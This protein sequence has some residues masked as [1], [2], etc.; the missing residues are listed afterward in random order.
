MRVIMPIFEFHYEG[1]EFKFSDNYSLGHFDPKKD[2][3]Q[4]V[5]NGLSVLD[6]S[7]ISQQSWA[8]VVTNPSEYFKEELNLLL[9]AFRIY[10]KSNVFI[11]W[12]FCEENPEFSTCL[13]DRFRNL[14]TE[15]FVN[16]TEED[17]SKVKDG[18]FKIIEMYS[19]SDR[20]KNALYFIWRGFCVDKH[21]DAYI[22]LVCAIESL[23]SGETAEEVTKTLIKR[24]QYFLSG[25]K[26]F[27]GNQINKIYEIR[28]DMVHGRIS[29][30][31]KANVVK[32]QKNLNNL[33]KLEELVFVCMKKMLDNKI[34]LKYRNIAEKEDFLNN[35]LNN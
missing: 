30:S 19:I 2:I 17:L 20:T 35:L 7:Y 8:L 15:P 25:I 10:A 12:R 1:N 33:A 23:F 13:N 32:R 27:G 29:H 16:I 11:K 18:F 31:D 24:I 14:V 34:Y 4:N 22:L 28:S 6:R 3:P 9:I 21:M 26:G 5:G